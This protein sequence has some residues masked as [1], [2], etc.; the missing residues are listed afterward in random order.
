MADTG[1]SNGTKA[2]D[3]LS[4]A[5][6]AEL[7]QRYGDRLSAVKCP[8]GSTWVVQRPTKSIWSLFQNSINDSKDKTVTLD[9]L[10]LDCVVYPERAQVAAAL[11]EYPAFSASLSNV[12]AEQAGQTTELDVKKL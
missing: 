8:D 11:T 12:L 7:K 1:D 2:T 3:G 4:P 9:T 6:V 10:A 5:A